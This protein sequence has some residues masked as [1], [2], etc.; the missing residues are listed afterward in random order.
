MQETQ[1]STRMFP[2]TSIPMQ[3]DGWL[4][5]EGIFYPCGCYNHA[6]CALELEDC[7]VWQLENKGYIHISDCRIT[8]KDTK[9]T[10]LQIDTLFDMQM[11]DPHSYMAMRINS[12]LQHWQE[13]E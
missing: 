9:P 12:Y 11:I 6:E 8:N 5:P 1:T 13:K 3:E 10:Q 4:T 7:T 2:P